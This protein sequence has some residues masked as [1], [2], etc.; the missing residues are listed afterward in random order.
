[1]RPYLD[2]GARFALIGRVKKLK[3][4]VANEAQVINIHEE[5]G[6]KEF[7]KQSMGIM[8]DVLISQRLPNAFLGNTSSAGS[9]F[10]RAM[11]G[12][13]LRTLGMQYF[14][15]GERYESEYNTGEKA[16]EE[17]FDNNNKENIRVREEK[18]WNSFEGIVRAAGM[19]DNP[20]FKKIEEEYKSG[21]LRMFQ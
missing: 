16:K 19:L 8:V 14:G 2:R 3:E 6:M 12:I 13:L 5:E 11:P 7:K 18:F 15:L 17:Y 20:E 1:M 21:K 9:L 10:A 4:Y